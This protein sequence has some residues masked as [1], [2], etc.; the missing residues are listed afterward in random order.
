MPTDTQH[1]QQQMDAVVIQANGPPAESL[2]YRHEPVPEPGP[3]EVLVEVH[4]AAVNPLDVANAAGRLGTPLPMIPGGDYA[5][6]VVSDGAHAGQEVWG[7]G[8]SLGMALGGKRPGTHARF[9]ALPGTW[10]SRKPERLSMTQAA[11]VGRSYFVAWQT[12]MNAME[13]MPAV[14]R[15]DARDFQR[16][17]TG[18]L[19]RGRDLQP[20]AAPHRTRQRVHGRG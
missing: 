14:R 18:R 16:P 5:G 4:A 12:V 17:R 20:A 8:P 19:P 15:P 7:S 9:V 2:A 10:L 1:S 13:L 11:A 3:G 6:I